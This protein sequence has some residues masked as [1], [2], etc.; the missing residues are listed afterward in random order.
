MAMYFKATGNIVHAEKD[1]QINKNAE[2]IQE[3][4]MVADIGNIT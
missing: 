4:E 1:R 3:K 2:E